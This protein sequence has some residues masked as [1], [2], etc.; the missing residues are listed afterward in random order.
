MLDAFITRICLMGC[1]HLE[2]KKNCA[3]VIAK[4]NK[5][6]QQ[7][8]YQCL[9]WVVTMPQTHDSVQTSIFVPKLIPLNLWIPLVRNYWQ[10]QCY[11]VLT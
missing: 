3:N 2:K 6:W 1:F 7:N 5:Q 4:E 11:D 9:C 10:N 8:V